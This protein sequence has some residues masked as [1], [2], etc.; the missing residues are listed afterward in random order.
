MKSDIRVGE[1]GRQE[2]SRKLEQQRARGNTFLM[3]KGDENV[4]QTEEE[5]TEV[6]IGREESDVFAQQGEKKAGGNQGDEERKMRPPLYQGTG[7][8]FRVLRMP[9]H[10]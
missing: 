2:E 10:T 9:K 7:T 8:S 3:D 4:K 1:E 5:W 6:S